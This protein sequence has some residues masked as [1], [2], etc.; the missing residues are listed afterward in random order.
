MRK[1]KA[2]SMVVLIALL[3]SVALSGCGGGKAAQQEMPKVV[4]VAD[5]TERAKQLCQALQGMF[6]DN[7]GIQVEIQSVDFKTRLEKMRNKDFSMVFAGWGADYDDPATFL[8]LWV[9][10]GDFND[11]YWSNPKYDELINKAKASSDQKERMQALAEAEKILL[12]ELPIAP[13]YWRAWPFVDKPWVKG[14]VRK[15]VGAEFDFKWAYTEGRPGKENELYWNLG[16]EP[17]SLDAQKS[18]DVVSFDILNAVLEGLVRPDPNGEIKKGS[19]LALDWTVSPDGKVYTFTLRDAKWSDGKPIT[20][21]D[22]EY[23]WKRAL[24]PRTGSQYAYQLYYLKGGQALNTIE[25]PDPNK[26]KAGYDQAVKKI[27][28]AMAN[29]GVKAKDAKT[30]EVTLEQPTP[31]F[32]WLTSFP[33]YLPQ[34]KHLVE[35]YGDKYASEANLM[36]ASGPFMVQSWKH[37]SEITLVKN[38]NYWD[39]ATVKLTKIHMDMIKDINTPLNMFEK[40]ELD[41]LYRVPGQFIDQYKDKGLKT[42]SEAT[43]WYLEF[44]CQDP[45]FKNAK[46]RQAFA[47]AVDRESFVKNVTKDGSWPATAYTPPV[48][49]SGPNESFQKTYVKDVLPVKADPEKAKKLLEEGL[50]ELGYKMPKA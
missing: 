12:Q 4:M 39:A 9:T 13:V 16:E 6:L 25:L 48:I 23:S 42:I 11:C 31:F 22:F 30:L 29:V 8:D 37:K 2:L 38:P 32:L 28:E 21:E 41:F 19:G 18:T 47:L 46:I 24:D 14:I 7:L 45:L 15:A 17:P 34:P 1:L 26:D 43:C 3:A 33:T 27:E 5:D 35:K 44:N 20:A 40:N 36:A 49:H 50:K 10:G